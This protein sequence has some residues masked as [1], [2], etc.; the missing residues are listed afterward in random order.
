MSELKMPSFDNQHQKEKKKERKLKCLLKNFSHLPVSKCP[1]RARQ[2][3][4]HL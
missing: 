1:R 2:G 3:G 4:T